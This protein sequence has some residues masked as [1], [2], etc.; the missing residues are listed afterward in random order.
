M[1]DEVMNETS[2]KKLFKEIDERFKEDTD[3]D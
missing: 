1:E 2:I 3:N